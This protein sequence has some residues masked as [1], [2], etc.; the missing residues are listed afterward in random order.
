MITKPKLV[1]AGGRLRRC[2]HLDSNTVHPIVLDSAHPL[3]KFLIQHYDNLLLHPGPECVFAE[4]RRKYWIIR[5][6]EAV[7]KHQRSCFECK[8]WRGKLEIPMMADLPQSNLRLLPPAFYSTGIDCFGP[9]QVKF[10]RRCKKNA[11]EYCT[12]ALLPKLFILNFYQALTQTSF[13]CR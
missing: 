11:W 13:L 3:I 10:G 12:S 5:G 6:R 4:L 9:F 8:K 1:R 2:N 7:K